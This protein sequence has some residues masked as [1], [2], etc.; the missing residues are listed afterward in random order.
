MRRS[1]F[2]CASLVLTAAVLAGCGSDSD[3]TS[4]DATSDANPD[5][6]SSSTAADGDMSHGT[7]GHGEPSPVAAGARRIDVSADALSFDPAEIRVAVGED[8]A[9]ALT[10]ADML[11]D[12]TVDDLEAHVPAEAGETVE[13]GFQATQPGNYSFYCSVEGHREAGMEGTLIVE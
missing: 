10:S 1:L 5:D 8:I 12:F 9:V 13:G 4:N 7:A 3:V 11:H 6:R 2:L